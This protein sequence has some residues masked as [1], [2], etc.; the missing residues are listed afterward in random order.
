MDK[1][2]NIHI[3][4]KMREIRESKNITQSQLAKLLSNKDKTYTYNAIHRYEV[5]QGVFG[6]DFLINLSELFDVPIEYFLSETKKLIIATENEK[7]I[8][9]KVEKKD[10]KKIFQLFY[11]LKQIQD[12]K[13][14][15]SI[16]DLLNDII[17][18]KNNA[19]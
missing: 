6:I 4:E 7:D 11:N 12:E 10:K 1:D 8:C 17:E 3:G 19:K 13:F 5:G 15:S 16:I 9:L 14:F 18:L 2:I